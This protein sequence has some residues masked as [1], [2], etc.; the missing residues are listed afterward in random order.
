MTN[1]KKSFTF[2]NTL[3][4]R[5]V[6]S[7]L[8]LFMHFF[9]EIEII[10]PEK[11]YMDGARMFAANHVSAFDAILVQLS[12]PRPV[13]FM[14]KAE[15]FRQPLKAWFFNQMGSFPVKRGEFDRQSVLNAKGVLDEGLALMM[16][17]EG[18]RTFGSGMLEAR[19]GTAHLA[20]RNHCPIVPVSICGAENILKNGLRKTQ[21][22]IIFC[23]A[24]IPGEHENAN[25]LTK[26]VMRAIAEQLPVQLRGYYA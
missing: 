15:L 18:T 16:F 5:F 25:Q 7:F 23:E 17:P 20:M 4:R 24:I 10:H 26:R 6:F 9:T 12:I 8:R 21:V 1:Q 11:I 13:C 2:K 14:S 19:N 22:K 3:F